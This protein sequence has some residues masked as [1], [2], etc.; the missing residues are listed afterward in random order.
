MRLV[1]EKLIR[2]SIFYQVVEE[3]QQKM[4]SKSIV[5]RLLKQSTRETDITFPTKMYTVFSL[6]NVLLE[7][8]FQYKVEYVDLL[9]ARI[10]Y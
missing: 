3:D 1:R 7:T 2:F 8:Y 4:T 5:G 10:T 6:S 9:S